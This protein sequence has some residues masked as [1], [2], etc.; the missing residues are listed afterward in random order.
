MLKSS[1]ISIFPVLVAFAAC[2]DAVLR[3]T[4]SNNEDAVAAVNETESVP[5][6]LTQAELYQAGLASGQLMEPLAANDDDVLPETVD[7]A[8]D[9]RFNAN[10]KL[11]A[12][13]ALTPE[14]AIAPETPAEATVAAIEQFFAEVEQIAPEQRYARKLEL[15]SN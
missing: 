14:P 9:V 3:S 5:N 1:F 15:L 8:P 2:S 6:V 11:A 13:K 12:F 7:V 4:E 10:D